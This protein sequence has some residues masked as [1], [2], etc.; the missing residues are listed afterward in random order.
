LSGAGGAVPDVTGTSQA[1]G[2]GDGMNSSQKT[3]PVPWQ[4]FWH[5]P[6]SLAFDI[7][8]DPQGAPA[9]VDPATPF[10][11]LELVHPSPSQYMLGP[12]FGSMPVGSLKLAGSP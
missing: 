10:R 7:Q 4:G 11:T 5:G 6:A 2:L 9:W 3:N 1:A 12:Q 8:S